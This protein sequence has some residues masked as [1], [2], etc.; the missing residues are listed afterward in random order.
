MDRRQAATFAADTGGIE[1]GISGLSLRGRPRSLGLRGGGAGS[2]PPPTDNKEGE[3]P[4]CCFSTPMAREPI[5]LW[6]PHLRVATC[7]PL[8]VLGVK[9]SGSRCRGKGSGSLLCQSKGRGEVIACWQCRQVPVCSW[10]V[11]VQRP[12]PHL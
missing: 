11:R 10:T 9:A 12:A 7:K 2:L 3:T 4:G 1:D 8:H 5:A 6:S